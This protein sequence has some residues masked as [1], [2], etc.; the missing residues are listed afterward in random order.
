MR[1]TIK[2]LLL[3]LLFLENPVYSQVQTPVDSVKLYSDI[4][5]Y[6]KRSKFNKFIYKLFFRPIA[7]API[8]KAVKIKKSKKEQQKP[9]SAYQGKIIRYIHIE[10]LDPFG[11]SITDTTRTPH[12]F[13]GRI[14]NKLHIKSQRITIRNLMLIHQNQP[15][16]SLLYKESERLIRSQQ[17]VQ[18]VT[19]SV[20]GTSKK[21]DSVDIYIR[22]LDKWTI[23]PR[24]AASTTKAK[25]N[26]IDRN[27]LGFGHE[28][29]NELTWYHLT[30]DY[31]Y[32]TKYYI[33]NIRNTFINTTAAYSINEY[34]A[35]TKSLAIDRP[36]Y[37][38]LTKYAG[39]VYFA[40]HYDKDSIL[41]IDT[42]FIDRINR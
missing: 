40:Q 41:S 33:P 2:L 35:Y 7:K 6:S 31:A 10:T 24:V 8:A 42:V 17:Y 27:F 23:I 12:N 5:K 18:D 39:G 3:F 36:F 9:I 25:V 32:Q 15:F 16:D 30:G 29:G 26:L 13:V 38:P 20:N 4:E 19:F 37:S 21:N 22:E 34:K 28:F 1:C 11:K 14:G